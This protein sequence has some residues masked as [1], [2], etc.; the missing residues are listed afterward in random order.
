MIYVN[1][2]SEA[3][4]ILNK[5][6]SNEDIVEAKDEI[7]ERNNQRQGKYSFYKLL[8]QFKNSKSDKY[9]LDALEFIGPIEIQIIKGK[10]RGL[11]A[12]R[13]IE[14]GEL[15]LAE[16]AFSLSGKRQGP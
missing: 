5:L 8:Q 9:N 3:L 14:Q 13:D 4:E 16:K 12:T 15:L 11:V 1:K 6:P 7:K 10:G 2:E